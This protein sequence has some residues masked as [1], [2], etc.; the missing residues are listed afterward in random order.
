[1]SVRPNTLRPSEFQDLKP[2]LSAQHHS[3]KSAITQAILKSWGDIVN[4]V[5]HESKKIKDLLMLNKESLQLY[6]LE[7]KVKGRKLYVACLLEE[8]RNDY[9]VISILRGFNDEPEA[10]ATVIFSYSGTR[11]KC[12]SDGRRLKEEIDSVKKYETVTLHTELYG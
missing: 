11:K 6:R 8:T 4:K 12:I 10:N 9:Y 7:R 3:K 5:S 1:M 2:V